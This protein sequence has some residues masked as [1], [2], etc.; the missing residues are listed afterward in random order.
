MIDTQSTQ[1]H[2]QHCDQELEAAESVSSTQIGRFAQAQV[3]EQVRDL[4]AVISS[5]ESKL[6][7]IDGMVDG[8]GPVEVNELNELL[9]E[10]VR[11][12]NPVTSGIFKLTG[13]TCEAQGDM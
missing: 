11:D 13:F 7:K 6:L 3:S 4:A 9:H 2:M 5:I 8:S 10:V 12:I 1:Q